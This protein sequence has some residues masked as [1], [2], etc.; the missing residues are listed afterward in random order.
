[1]PVSLVNRQFPRYPLVV[2]VLHKPRVP[3][4]IRP[5]IGWTRNLSEGGACVELAELLPSHLPLRMLLQADRGPIQV[6]AEVVW[7]TE[8]DAA[9]EGVSHGVTFTQVPPDQ[10]QIL[11]N[12][13]ASSKGQ[14]RHAGVRLPIEVALTYRR[15]DQAGEPLEGWTEMVSRGG[16]LL[17]LPQVLPPGTALEMT[18]HLANELL[19]AEGTIVWVEPQEKRI[20]GEPVRHGLRFT[21]LG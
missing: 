8:V 6:E 13:L 20:P 4:G 17:R 9:G 14:Q 15:K 1:M 7:A 19:A 11:R 12:L 16:L 3:M 5:G 21:A 10:L 2:P 18:L